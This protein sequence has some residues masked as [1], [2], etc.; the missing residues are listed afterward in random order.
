MTFHIKARK[1]IA[2]AIAYDCMGERDKAKKLLS[3][4]RTYLQ[5][6]IRQRRMA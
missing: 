5:R 6:A 3:I 4:A 2:F 1:A